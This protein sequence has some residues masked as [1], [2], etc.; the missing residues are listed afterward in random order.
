MKKYTVQ[1][2]QLELDA[3]SN[4]DMTNIECL[5]ECLTLLRVLHSGSLGFY[6]HMA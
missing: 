5:D 1:V 3:K 4:A 2:N 6:V